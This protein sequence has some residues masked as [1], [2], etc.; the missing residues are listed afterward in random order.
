MTFSVFLYSLV[1]FHY[2]SLHFYLPTFLTSFSPSLIPSTHNH[3]FHVSSFFLHFS[4]PLLL[5]FFLQ[6]S[7][8][9]SF[10]PY[11][12][13]TLSSFPSTVQPIKFSE[14]MLSDNLL[15][16]SLPYSAF[17]LRC[18]PMSYLKAI[19]Q[20]GLCGSSVPTYD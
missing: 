10:L 2:S 8:P 13:S 4:I 14:L 7:F 20:H 3:L 6:P 11:S 17:A 12:F 1:S 15:C 18:H 16:S 5:H 19:S 9:H